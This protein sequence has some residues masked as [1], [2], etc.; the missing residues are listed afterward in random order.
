MSPEHPQSPKRLTSSQRQFYVDRLS[1][2][3][4]AQGLLSNIS[5]DLM[6]SDEGAKLPH[7]FAKQREI[8]EGL[9]QLG[10]SKE[11]IIEAFQFFN[12]P[13]QQEGEEK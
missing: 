8:S 4:E 13:Y 10:L 9:Q 12:I 3:Q 6:E 2:P 11:Q 5:S 1:F 7:D